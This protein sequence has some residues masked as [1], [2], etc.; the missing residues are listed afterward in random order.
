M[1]LPQIIFV[2]IIGINLLCTAYLHGKPKDGKYS[3]WSSL[4][5]AAI[6]IGLLMWGGF[7]K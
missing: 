7:F 6:L 3:F 5:S 4:S 1:R 2:S